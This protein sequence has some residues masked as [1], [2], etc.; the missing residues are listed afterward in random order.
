MGIDLA[1]QIRTFLGAAALGGCLGLVYD[2]LRLL[3]RRLRLPL[4]GQLLDLG[5]WGVTTVGLFA[6]A[7]T[8]GGGVL[9]IY[10]GAALVLGAALYFL[11]LSPPARL[12]LGLAADGVAV[13]LRLLLLP[14]K[15]LAGFEK[16][17]E[18]T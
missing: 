3:R 9:R 16:K 10:M 15:G 17:F 18:K 1:E 14:V 7:I 12:L 8:V 5:F 2:V 11:L 13:V 6:Y 4:M